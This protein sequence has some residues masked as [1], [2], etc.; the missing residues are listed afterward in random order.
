MTLR[1][2][3]VELYHSTQSTIAHFM[4]IAVACLLRFP[5]VTVCRGNEILLFDK[6][7][8]RRRQAIRLGLKASTLVIYNQLHMP[9]TFDRLGIPKEKRFFFAN[10]V[11]YNPQEP[12]PSKERSAVLFLNTWHPWRHPEV[13]VEI[14]IRL[15]R[16]FP[17]VDF[18][19]AGDRDRRGS[20]R[21]EFEERI[22][23]AGVADRFKLMPYVDRPQELYRKSNIF[24]L[25]A[26]IVFLNFSL[27]EAMERG[28]TP[29]I[30]RV[31][32]A[33][34][35]VEHGVSGLIVDLDGD[36]FVRAVESLLSR[37][38]LLE[39]LCT[40]ARRRIKE[41]F[42]LDQGIGEVIAAYETH[43]WRDHVDRQ[44]AGVEI[45]AASE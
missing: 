11:P 20:L 9:E 13:M 37:P 32:G 21:K 22:L 6:H 15:A 38:E 10:R 26:E 43:V 33:E 24:V 29:V 5:L 7:V 30:S 23:S 44:R 16:K 31:D 28:M 2:T 45:T 39:T 12:T 14:G 27:L 36:S 18:I 3:H 41:K 34:R 19:L 40:G 8:W 4:Y 35:I 42:D 1:P 25:P 17:S